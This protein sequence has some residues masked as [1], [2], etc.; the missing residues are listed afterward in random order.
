MPT[1]IVNGPNQFW[2]VTCSITSLNGG[3]LNVTSEDSAGN[4]QGTFRGTA[5][6]NGLVDASNKVS[7]SWT[8]ALS[9]TWSFS[10]GQPN[11]TSNPTSITGGAVTS[12]SGLLTDTD[13][14]WSASAQAGTPVEKPKAYGA[15]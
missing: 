7:F 11:S 8:D 10:G 9:N 14:T 2:N 5:V 1:I 12:S 15:K 3:H 4:F 6:S 13:G